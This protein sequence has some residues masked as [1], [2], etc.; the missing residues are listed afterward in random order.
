MMEWPSASA[1]PTSHCGTGTV[2]PLH[3]RTAGH[4]AQVRANRGGAAALLAAGEHSALHTVSPASRC[5]LLPGPHSFSAS[6][7]MLLRPALLQVPAGAGALPPAA[8][9]GAAHLQAQRLPSG[10]PALEELRLDGLDVDLE[11]GALTAL[12]GLDVRK[13]CPAAAAVAGGAGGADLSVCPR[14]AAAFPHQP[15]PVCG[16]RC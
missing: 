1:H 7:L 12:T 5:P 9:R 4:A 15:R 11:G 2:P 3:R 10:L 14:P 6:P 13:A 16:P 8:Q